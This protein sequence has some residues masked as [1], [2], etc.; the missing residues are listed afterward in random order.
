MDLGSKDEDREIVVCSVD[1]QLN[2]ALGEQEWREAC[3]EEQDMKYIVEGVASGWS[4][5]SLDGKR[6]VGFLVLCFVPRAV[7]PEYAESWNGM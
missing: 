2:G 1:E 5:W 7:E 6:C 4:Q 3:D